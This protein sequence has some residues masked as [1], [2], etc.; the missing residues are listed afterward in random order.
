MIDSL[1]SII[2][3]DSEIKILKRFNNGSFSF[4]KTQLPVGVVSSGVIIRP[5]AFADIINYLKKESKP[6]IKNNDF[7]IGL[8]E[9]FVYMQIIEIP[10]VQENKIIDVIKWQADKLLSF[11][12]DNVYLDYKIID[13]KG[14]KLKI[15]V[16]ATNREIIDSLQKT[17]NIANLNI[18][19]V[20]SRSGALANILDHSPH[21]LEIIVSIDK[22]SATLVIAKNQ[23]ARFSTV[24]IYDNDIDRLVNKIEESIHYY[25]TRKE[26][27]KKISRLFF[28]AALSSEQQSS[29]QNKFKYSIHFAN[30]KEIFGLKARDELIDYIDNFGLLMGHR[31]G[32]NLI[33]RL[34]N[35]EICKKGFV[36][37]II[38]L[39]KLSLT[40][41]LVLIVG[42]IC[43]ILFINGNN[44]VISKRLENLKEQK[45]NSE[46][47]NLE[48]KVIELNKKVT[49]MTELIGNQKQI[50]PRIDNIVSDV[51]N[52]GNLKSIKYTSENN[53]LSVTGVVGNRDDLQLIQHKINQSKYIKSNSFPLKNLENSTTPPFEFNIIIK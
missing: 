31:D 50:I 41:W 51:F 37:Y 9:K 36:T 4:L 22:D 27:D 17:F 30:L 10:K 42:Q 24:I 38:K 21:N 43:L 16:T 5:L 8:S 49:K 46:S 11:S 45:I 6:R 13:T 40:L 12:I 44:I 3:T 25:L 19:T 26:P 33:P 32:I 34:T 18:V 20:D 28:I 14:G 35:V 7:I 23:I 15:L 39:T 2:Y 53:Q 1:A 48:K 47:V 29:I 52:N